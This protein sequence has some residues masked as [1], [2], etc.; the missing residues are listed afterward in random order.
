MRAEAVEIAVEI[1][2]NPSEL[3]TLG[4]AVDIAWWSISRTGGGR[5][6]SLDARA[7]IVP[8]ML[9]A[10]SLGLGG[11]GSLIEYPFR[12]VH[13][14]AIGVAGRKAA[15]DEPAAA[16]VPAAAPPRSESEIGIAARSRTLCGTMGV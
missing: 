8:P 5:R 11:G 4:G 3:V 15:Q 16:A 7:E 12:P 6:R 14:G 10:P 9:G 13:L 2:R 1:R